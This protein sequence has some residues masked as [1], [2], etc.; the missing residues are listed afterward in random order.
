MDFRRTK[1]SRRALSTLAITTGLLLAVAG[2][3]G[4]GDDD[5]DKGGSS[6]APSQTKSGETEKESQTPSRI[7]CWQRSRGRAG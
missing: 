3:G 6:S 4:G 5:S 7:L 2:C 1:K